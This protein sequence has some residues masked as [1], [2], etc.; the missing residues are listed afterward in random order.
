MEEITP[1][2]LPPHPIIPI[3]MAEFALLPKAIP[4]LT[5]VTAERA[6][7]LLIKFLRFR[8]VIIVYVIGFD[9]VS[10]F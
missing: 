9:S 4:G 6:A 7:V 2:P 3:L 10:S 1:V 8:S 5:I